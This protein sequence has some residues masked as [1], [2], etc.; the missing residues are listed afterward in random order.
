MLLFSRRIACLIAAV[1]M[2]M[3][4]TQAS[5][6][7]TGTPPA[8][9][10]AVVDMIKVRQT[11]DAL[12]SISE[13]VASYRDAFQKD[14]QSEEASLREANQELARQRSILSAEAFEQERKNFE[15][16]VAEV[17]RGV[18]QRKAE[19]EQVREEAMRELHRNLNTVIAEIAEE[20][21]LVLVLPRAQTILSAKN[22][23]ITDEVTKRLNAKLPDVTVPKPGQ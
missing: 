22:L 3:V 21:G 11:S 1:G 15:A 12:R 7:E 5:A 18:Q 16:R 23:E 17:Q 10:I 20:R 19:L 14:I 2:L 4:T 8:L 9:P 6:Q 13:Q